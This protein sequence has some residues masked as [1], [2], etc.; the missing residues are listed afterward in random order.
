MPGTLMFKA[1]AMSIS[2]NNNNRDAPHFC[3]VSD[4][5]DGAE[6]FLVRRKGCHYKTGGA[7]LFSGKQGGKPYDGTE[8]YI[9]VAPV[10]PRVDLYVDELLL[11]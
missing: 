2:E 1:M 5:A 6:L 8:G 3:R 10:F 7:S 11:E 9:K 4:A